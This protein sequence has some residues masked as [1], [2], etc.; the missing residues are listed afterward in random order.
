MHAAHTY[1]CCWLLLLWL[2]GCRRE[3]TTGRRKAACARARGSWCGPT[4]IHTSATSTTASGM[5]KVRSSLL[6]QQDISLLVVC[7]STHHRFT[8]RGSRSLVCSTASIS[9]PLPKKK[10]RTRQHGV[11]S[12]PWKFPAYGIVFDGRSLRGEL[13][14]EVM[15]DLIV[16][17]VFLVSKSMCKLAVVPLGTVKALVRG[18][19]AYRKPYRT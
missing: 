8:W 14:Q 13:S 6:L 15:S 1:I 4:E 17:R 12:A 3:N 10:S 9:F 16:D 19:P 18:H 11:L 7:E 5:A 2:N